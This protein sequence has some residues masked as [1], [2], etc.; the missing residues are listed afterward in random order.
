LSTIVKFADSL[1]ATE[2]RYATL[3][4][5]LAPAAKLLP[6][7]FA[8]IRKHPAYAPVVATELIVNGPVPL[9]F[10]VTVWLALVVFSFCVPKLRLVG[11]RLTTGAVPVPV[12]ATVCGDPAALSVISKLAVLLPTAVGLNVTTAV[13]LAPTAML[14]PQLFTKLKSP[15]FVPPTVIELISKAAVPVFFTVMVWLALAVPVF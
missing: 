5:Q 12:S 15:A 2:G 1:A 4:I 11:A 7:A 8:V 9:F 13:R 14:D 3:T 6:H 10:T